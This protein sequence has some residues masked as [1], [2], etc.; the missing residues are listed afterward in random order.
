ML[1]KYRFAAAVIARLPDHRWTWAIALCREARLSNL[2]LVETSIETLRETFAE[3]LRGSVVSIDGAL[4][5]AENMRRDIAAAEA[6]VA[7]PGE[8][9]AF[10]R[11]YCWQPWYIS[12][13]RTQPDSDIAQDCASADGIEIVR[14][15]TG[16]RAILHAC[17]LTYALVLRLDEG[18]TQAHVYRFWH[19]WLAAVLRRRFGAQQI[20]F[21][22]AQPDFPMLYRRNR[23]G[24]SV[25][26]PVP[27]WKSSGRDANSSAVHSDSTATS[28]FSTARCSLA[29]VTSV[30]RT[31]CETVP[32]RTHWLRTW[33]DAVPRSNRSAARPFRSSR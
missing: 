32:R 30:C 28:F 15:P 11:F 10:V 29:R 2:P 18:L 25:S 4:A 8:Q 27:D 23:H 21:A 31:T 20:A 16:G 12:I 1:P 19:E 5:G 7:D 26:P 14:R 22:R 9:R 3:R 13:G 24:G 33:R 6:L 17:E